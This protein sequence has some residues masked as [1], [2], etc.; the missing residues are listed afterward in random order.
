MLRARPRPLTP[1]DYDKLNLKRILP[2]QAVRALSA[3]G[4]ALSPAE[5]RSLQAA[6]TDADG[7]FAYARLVDDV[8]DTRPN[9]YLEREPVTDPAMAV[10]AAT[11]RLASSVSALTTPLALLPR[12]PM[13]DERE[14]RLRGVLGPLREA[15]KARG[16]VVKV[17]LKD[18]DKCVGRKQAGRRP[19][20]IGAGVPLEGLCAN[21]ARAAHR[22]ML[23]NCCKA[24]E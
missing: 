13:S 18:F 22:S 7:F 21:C 2:E 24:T 20:P 12:E 19:V 17:F 3:A 23:H 6:Y 16:L 15:V 1:Q 14:A 10:S 8:N 4:L 9:G 5:A 11:A